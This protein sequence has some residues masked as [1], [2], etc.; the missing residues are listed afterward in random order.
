MCRGLRCDGFPQ[1]HSDCSEAVASYLICF[2]FVVPFL[3]SVNVVSDNI[4][5]P[6]WFLYAL[7]HFLLLL[8]PRTLDGDACSC[9]RLPSLAPPGCH[10]PCPSVV[11]DRLVG[12]V[13]RCPP[14]ER[15]IPGS[16][17]ACAGIFSGASHT[18][19]LKIG[20]PVATLPGAWRYWVSTGTGRPGV[21]IL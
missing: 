5:F 21:S 16:N 15:K 6:S 4:S 13:V 20:T 14:R 12:L 18:S 1:F 9:K 19:D 2:A 7:P 8:L 3:G 10:R 11:L 17:P